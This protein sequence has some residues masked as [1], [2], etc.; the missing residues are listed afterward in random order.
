[1]T[2]HHWWIVAIAAVYVA[3]LIIAV[4]VRPWTHGDDWPPP[5]ETWAPA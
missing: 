2:R 1:M 3:L 4:T 5:P